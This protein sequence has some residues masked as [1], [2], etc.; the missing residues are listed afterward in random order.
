[1]IPSL[2]LALVLVA[3]VVVRLTP[4]VEDDKIV[5][6]AQSVLMGILKYFPTIGLNP[7]TKRMKEALE[8]LQAKDGGDDESSSS[9]T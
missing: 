3:T 5:G 7:N 8:A 4:S 2:F 1:M 6:K 9:A